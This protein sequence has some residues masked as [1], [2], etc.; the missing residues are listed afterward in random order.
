MIWERSFKSL[1]PEF[2]IKNIPAFLPGLCLPPLPVKLS[3]PLLEQRWHSLAYYKTDFCTQPCSSVVLQE[4][5]DDSQDP[6][7][8]AMDHS[9]DEFLF[10]SVTPSPLGKRPRQPRSKRTTTLVEE[11]LDFFVRRMTRSCAKRTGMK[12]T[13]AI[14]IKPTPLRRPKA[15]KLKFDSAPRQDIPLPPP[16]PISTLQAVGAALG[17]AP[18]ELTVEKLTAPPKSDPKQDSSN[19]E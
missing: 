4:I 3:S 2:L 17:I 9:Q 15:K 14:S 5:P 7:S 19:D 12:P 16:T 1:L 13:S 6:A 18:E 10:T 8:Q 11:N